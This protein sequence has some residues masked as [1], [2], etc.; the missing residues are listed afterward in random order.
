NSFFLIVLC[1]IL[2]GVVAATMMGVYLLACL[3]FTGRH[4]N[5]AFSALRIKRYKNFLRM[6]I[7]PQGRLSIYPI[8]LE[9]V[10]SDQQ[11]PPANP[12]L[13]PKLIEP[14]IVIS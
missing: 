14:A 12:T 13:S 6:R 7:D 8:G 11:V 5:E 2:G 4:W 3:T 9:D 1:G 10:P